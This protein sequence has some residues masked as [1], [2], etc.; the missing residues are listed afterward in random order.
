MQ[1]GV[2]Q[3]TAKFNRLQQ[4]TTIKAYLL[5]GESSRKSKGSLHLQKFRKAHV[6]AKSY[7]A[8]GMMLE[9]L[10]YS[11]SSSIPDWRGCSV[12]FRVSQCFWAFRCRSSLTCCSRAGS[13]RSLTWSRA[14]GFGDLEVCSRNWQRGGRQP[15]SCPTPECYIPTVVLVRLITH[16]VTAV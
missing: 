14:W 5:A 10:S 7:S 8:V 12:P 16:R 6:A 1:E 15:T 9:H 11:P 4:E 3:I 2:W 13:S